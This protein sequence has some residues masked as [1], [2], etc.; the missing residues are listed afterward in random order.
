MASDAVSRVLESA[1]AGIGGDVGPQLERL[2]GQLTLLQTVNQ[3]ALESV[4]GNTE[5]VRE[6]VEV[7]QRDSPDGRSVGGTILSVLGAGLGL[8]PLISGVLRLFGGGGG[9]TEP[10]PLVR[11]ALPAARQVSGG[12]SE[13]VPQ[14]FGV[15]YGQGQMP[16][17][18]ASAV[19]QV[20]VQVNAMDSRSFLDHSNEIALAVRQ[21]MLESSVLSDVVREA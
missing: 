3:A 14:A 10:P 18:V 9:S 2:T 19:P 4:R 11:F 7:N 16:R 12:I 6:F 1:L 20:T 17:A 13:G 15:D 5:A 8:S 21:A